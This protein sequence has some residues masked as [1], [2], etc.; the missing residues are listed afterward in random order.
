MNSYKDQTALITGASSGIG[1]ALAQEL[2]KRGA[3]VIL[4]AR[5]EEKLNAEVNIIRNSGN[6]AFAFSEDL[7]LAGS[8]E[9]LYSKIKESNL[10]IDLLINNAGYGRWGEFTEFD[11]NDYARMIQLNITSLTDLCRLAIPDMAKRGHGGVINLG[12]TASFL[13]VPYASVYSASKAYVLMF[14]EAIRYEYEG[15]GIRVMTL[16]PGATATEFSR[17]ASENSSAE[18]KA[19]NA[20]LAESGQVGMSSKD[21]AIEGL[22]AF[23]EN[24]VYKIAG[25]ENK[26]FALL[27]RILSRGRALKLAGDSFRKRVAK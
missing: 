25:N 27:P 1:L 5:S 13:P 10:T 2:S 23:L 16:C 8:A 17:V 14:S 24:K 9:R 22:N 15:K 3:R 11:A 21:V 19:L 26:K 12:S 4:T 6:E 20:K 18:L 7:S